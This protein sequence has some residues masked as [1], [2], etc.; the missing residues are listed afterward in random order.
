MASGAILRMRLK[1]TTKVNRFLTS[2]PGLKF[3]VVTQ[4][5]ACEVTGRDT[6]DF[7]GGVTGFD[8]TP[9]KA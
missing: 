3:R 2:E 9:N 8:V 7:I 6:A 5:P 1:A 4:V